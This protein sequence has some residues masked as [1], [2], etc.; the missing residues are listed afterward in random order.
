MPHRDQPIL[1]HTGGS[2]GQ[3]SA[4]PALLYDDLRGLIPQGCIRG[5][6]N[7]GHC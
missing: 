6:A 5:A 2:D 3:A 4:F 1:R 7:T